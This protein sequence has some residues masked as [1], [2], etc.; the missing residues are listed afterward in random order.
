MGKSVDRPLYVLIIGRSY[1]GNQRAENPVF[2]I[3]EEMEKSIT[4]LGD[5]EVEFLTDIPWR[6]KSDF[7]ENNFAWSLQ[8]L[9]DYQPVELLSE[10]ESYYCKS[11]DPQDFFGGFMDSTIVIRGV[12]ADSSSRT[13]TS[14]LTHERVENRSRIRFSLNCEFVREKDGICNYETGELSSRTM[15]VNLDYQEPVFGWDTWSSSEHSPST[16][17]YFTQFIEGLRP[18]YYNA[19]IMPAPPLSCSRR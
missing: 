2:Q 6:H 9:P 18:D 14:Q 3:A 10:K 12:I 11:N 8:P 15:T 7:G 16:T 13:I 17:L 1:G 5:V 4:D 19:V